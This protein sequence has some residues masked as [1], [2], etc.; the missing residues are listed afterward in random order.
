MTGT[1]KETT[2]ETQMPLKYTEWFILGMT[3]QYISHCVTQNTV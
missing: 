3:H 1:N 2:E